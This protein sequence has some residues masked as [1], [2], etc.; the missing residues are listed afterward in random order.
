M[1]FLLKEVTDFKR[2]TIFCLYGAGRNDLIRANT[3]QG[4]IARVMDLPTSKSL[5]QGP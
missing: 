5:S 1:S 3:F 4:P 2:N